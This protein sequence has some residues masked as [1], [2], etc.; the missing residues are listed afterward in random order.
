MNM[1]NRVLNP[2]LASVYAPYAIAQIPRLLSHL[3][4][5]E[6]SDTRGCFDRDHWSW[7]FRDFPLGMVQSAAYPLALLWR[8]PFPENPY[9]RSPRVLDWISRALEFT[10]ERQHANGAFD[11]FSPNEQ[12]GGTTL[13]VLHGTLEAFR[14]V[15]DAVREGLETRI[16]EAT[17][18][19]CAFTFNYDEDHGFISNHRALFAVALLDAHELLNDNSYRVRAEDLIQSILA[20]QSPDGWFQEYGGPD[21]GYESLGISHL[22]VYWQRTG[23]AEL[24]ASLQRAVEFYSWCVHPDGSAGGVYGSRQTALYFPGGFELLAPT[25]PLAAAV[26][27]F[28]RER[29]LRGNVVT[30][31]ISDLENLPPLL[32]SY[33]EAG[34]A[35]ASPDSVPTLPCE[36]FEGLVEF[37]D[38]GISVK[39]TRGFYFV[40]N[41]SKGGVCRAFDKSTGEL[42]YEDAGYLVRTGKRRWISQQMTGMGHRTDPELGDSITSITQFV[43]FRQELLTPARFIF[44]RLLNLTLFT[45]PALGAWLRRQIVRRLVSAKRDGPF[46]LRRS[47]AFSET[48]ITIHDRLEKRSAATA[49]EVKLPRSLLSIHMGSARYF[50]MSDLLETFA[51]NTAG[52]S[53]S[54]NQNGYAEQRWVLR[55]LPVQSFEPSN[56]HPEVVQS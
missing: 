21:P 3:D 4:R 28:M 49:D 13:G 22:A 19:A 34:L 26:A 2:H 37:K 47:V 18:R 16:A 46:Q 33:L 20:Q 7:K 40:S 52:M 53:A 15:R 27:R 36:S 42:A 45:S 17:A 9:Y 24:L 12:D 11:A 38:S 6:F 32:Y 31:A 41:A 48:S 50:H 23:S 35:P 51:V 55:F 39:A 29:L 54:L 44:L 30:P 56:T 8:Y 10:L 5:D 43:E 14:V 25:V 1:D